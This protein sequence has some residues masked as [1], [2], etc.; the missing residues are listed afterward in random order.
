MLSFTEAISEIEKREAP[1]TEAQIE[2]LQEIARDIFKSLTLGDVHQTTA[3]GNE[4]DK[5]R[6][7]LK[8]RLLSTITETRGS[9][10]NPAPVS[11]RDDGDDGTLAKKSDEAWSIPLQILKAEPDQQ[12][13]FGWASIVEKDGQLIIDKQ[14]DVIMP[15]DLEKA[16]YD[17]VLYSR[18]QGD[19]H[20]QKG[21]GRLI[22]SMVFTKQKQDLLGI[23]LGLQGWFVGF[24]VDSPAVW[25]A[26]KSGERPEL[27]IGGSGQ[28]FDI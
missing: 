19:M 14:D 28:R 8:D 7:P 16:A 3:L 23:D 5:K 15:E 22:E 13:I 24:R 21:V 12:L 1:L 2:K 18:D 27:S 9:L 17:F 10:Q 25:K 4:K 11:L 26:I 20:E 6:K